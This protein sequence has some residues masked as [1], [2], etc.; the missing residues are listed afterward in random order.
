MDFVVGFPWTRRKNDSIWVIIDRLTKLA[1]FIPV[2]SYY[3]SREYEILYLEKIVSFH[4]IPLSIIFYRRAQF[5][6]CF[7]RSFQKG[8]DTSVKL[9]TTFHPQTDDQVESTIQTLED[10]L[11][12]C[13]I[14]FNGS[15]DDYLPLI[16]LSY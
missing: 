5:T 11:R 6:F 13:V 16:E 2:R 12:Y 1:H 15:L 9:I 14:D 7:W 10:I 4:G 8:L 3:S